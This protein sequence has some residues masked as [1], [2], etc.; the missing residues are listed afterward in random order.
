MNCKYSILEKKIFFFKGEIYLPRRK[1]YISYKLELLGVGVDLYY[2]SRD[3]S[4]GKKINILEHLKRRK[5]MLKLTMVKE[6]RK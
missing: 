5:Q 1:I 4:P 3:G 2:F 6:I